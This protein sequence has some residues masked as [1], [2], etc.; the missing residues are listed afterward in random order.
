MSLLVLEMVLPLPDSCDPFLRF[1][2]IV[3]LQGCI[4]RGHRALLLARHGSERMEGGAPPN[5]SGEVETEDKEGG[6]AT[7][8]RGQTVD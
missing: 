6:G 5:L 4:V 3:G 7:Q 2:S 1:D 8:G